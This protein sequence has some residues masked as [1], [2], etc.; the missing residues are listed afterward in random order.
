MAKNS[1]PNL[2]ASKKIAEVATR[3]E[4]VDY[5]IE[6][7]ELPV[8]LKNAFQEM[9]EL[10][11]AN[12]QASQRI[13]SGNVNAIN[14]TLNMQ[15][16]IAN[17]AI[18]T[19]EEE[20]IE[21]QNINHD[22]AINEQGEYR[23]AFTVG[24]NEPLSKEAEEACDMLFNDWLAEQGYASHD[25]RIYELDSEG[26]IKVDNAGRSVAAKKEELERR[27]TDPKTGFEQYMEKKSV[28]VTTYMREFPTAEVEVE[29]QGPAPAA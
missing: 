24:D 20:I 5:L 26:E 19:L 11:A 22:I 23:R 13:W 25:S 18:D 16:Y 7:Y 17:Q 4:A 10:H 6:K 27:L 29:P 3:I 8:D 21:D 1:S 2:V 9:R 12:E 28:N 14:V 15:E